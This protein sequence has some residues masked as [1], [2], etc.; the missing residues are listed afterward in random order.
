MQESSVSR[1]STGVP[2]RSCLRRG[3]V[4]LSTGTTCEKVMYH[5]SLKISLNP[6]CAAASTRRWPSGIGGSRR[7]RRKSMTVSWVSLKDSLLEAGLKISTLVPFNSLHLF[8]SS[9]LG[10]CLPV[11]RRASALESPDKQKEAVQTGRDVRKG[12]D[13]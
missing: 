7:S 9:D 10:L 6:G 1:R 2:T 4:N 8:C 12:G 5:V 11:E 3:L 13:G